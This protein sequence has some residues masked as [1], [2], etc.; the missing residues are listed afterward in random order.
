MYEKYKIIPIVSINTRMEHPEIL[1]RMI[2][3]SDVVLLPELKPFE[4]KEKYGSPCFTKFQDEMIRRYQRG[5]RSKP[6]M[7]AING[8]NPKFNLNNTARELL[9]SDNLHKVSGECCNYL[10]KKPAKKYQKE[11]NLLPILGVRQD[12]GMMRKAQYT[13][14]FTS[15]K[16]F[17]PLHDMNSKLFEE[18]YKQ[19]NIPIPKV[20]KHV[21]RTGCM[22]CPYGR[23]TKIELDLLPKNRRNYII[24]YFKE[25]YDVLGI[26]YQTIQTKLDI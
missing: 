13:S 17:T 11:N 25:S 22:G 2:D 6:L 8:T 21:S 19:Y 10:K 26:E 4:I 14:C 1:R 5:L 20:Y 7:K 15:D 3:N 9:L 16:K 12:E 18:I 23:H 24:K